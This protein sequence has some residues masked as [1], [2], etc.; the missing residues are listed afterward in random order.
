MNRTIVAL[1][2]GAA[3]CAAMLPTDV[4][5][6]GKH[7]KANPIAGQ[8]REQKMRIKDAVKSGKLSRTEAK[9]LK[10]EEKAFRA[11]VKAAKANGKISPED[12]ERLTSELNRL[13]EDINAKVGH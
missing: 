3:L 6:A 1:M 9:G 7:A 13:N 5:A 4:L 8:Q 10:S 11:E 2:C 12:R